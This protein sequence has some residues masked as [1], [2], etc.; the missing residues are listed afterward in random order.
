M[1][2][3]DIGLNGEE[4]GNY[5]IVENQMV[6]DNL[7]FQSV[8]QKHNLLELLLYMIL[9][10]EKMRPSVLAYNDLQDMD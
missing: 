5:Y 2:L 10:K 6:Q 8:T 9:W 1:L 4:N 7:R 3:G